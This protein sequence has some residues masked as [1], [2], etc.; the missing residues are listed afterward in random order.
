MVNACLVA[1]KRTPYWPT[2]KITTRTTGGFG[3]MHAPTLSLKTLEV[4]PSR[5]SWVTQFLYP[6]CNCIL[7]VVKAARIARRE[8]AR[9]GARHIL[10]VRLRLCLGRDCGPCRGS[11]CGGREGH[12]APQCPVGCRAAWRLSF[13]PA[14]PD[15]VHCCSVRPDYSALR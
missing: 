3:H 2:M 10:R 9:R 4:G 12:S 5:L 1:D 14:T 13:G 7:S 8:H 11:R 6:H 15:N